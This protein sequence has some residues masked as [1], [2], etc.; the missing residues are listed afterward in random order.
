MKG[1]PTGLLWHHRL[2]EAALKRLRLREAYEL[3]FRGYLNERGWF[4]SFSS[5]PPHDARGN[6][7]PWI[8]Y[9]AIDFLATRITPNARVFEYGSGQSTLW[10][11]SRVREIVALEHDEKWAA[12]VR[13]KL[14]PNARLLTAPLE[15]DGSAYVRAIETVEGLF[16]IVIVDGRK[17]IDCTRAAFDRLSSIG[18]VL[19]DDAERDRY[20]PAFDEAAA[21]GFK[22]LVISGMKP[23]SYDASSLAIFYRSGS[24]VLDL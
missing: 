7:I 4:E 17:R 14:P 10:W 1:E 3:R 21:R 19:L 2:F 16:D 8:N 6:P 22:R 24:N 13:P 18:V 9:S 5:E 20:R 11:A 12:L 15:G 23:K